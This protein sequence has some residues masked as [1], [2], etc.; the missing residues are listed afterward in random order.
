M[1]NKTRLKIRL[2]GK[3]VIFALLL[4]LVTP[5]TYRMTAIALQVA[6]I[7]FWTTVITLGG[8]YAIKR[9]IQSMLADYK[10]IRGKRK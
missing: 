10:K 3:T 5:A 1:K 6:Y 9:L 7:F 8:G 2:L 4:I